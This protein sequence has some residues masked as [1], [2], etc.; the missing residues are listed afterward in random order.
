MISPHC[1]Q[2][3]SK[4][5]SD[6]STLLPTTAFLNPSM[7]PI[8]FWLRTRTHNINDVAPALLISLILGYSEV[9]PLRALAHA[10]A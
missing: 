10:L 6:Y 3:C 5:R 8:A 9:S 4:S 7:C 2:N 1:S